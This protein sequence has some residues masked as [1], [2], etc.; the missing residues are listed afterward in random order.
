MNDSIEPLKDKVGKQRE[1]LSQSVLVRDAFVAVC[2]A[3]GRK[4]GG[5]DQIVDSKI[6]QGTNI[7]V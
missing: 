6:F 2:R 4:V 7:R 5:G 3:D 1:M